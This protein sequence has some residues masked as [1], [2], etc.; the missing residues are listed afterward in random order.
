L[1]K[2]LLVAGILG[3]GFSVFTPATS[4][5]QR[6]LPTYDDFRRIDRMRR[7]NGELQT[8]E[9]M[10]VTQIDRRL[11]QQTALRATNDFQVV[12][13]GAELMGSWPMKRDLFDAALA[14]SGSNVMVALRYACTAAQQRDEDTAVALLHFAEK[15]DEGNAVPWLVELRLLQWE[16]KDFAELKLPVG[17]TIHYRDY[18][19]E[20]ARARIKLLEAAGYS[21]Y[22]AR[23]LGFAPETPVLSAARELTNQPIEKAAGPFVLSVARA[24]Q[25][26]PMYLLTELVGE[27][28]ERAATS[29]GV[30]GQTSAEANMRA[31]ELDRRRDTIKALVSSVERNAVDI[32]TE[33]EMVQ[34]FDDV[35]NLGE[36][37][38]MR[39]LAGKIQG[40]PLP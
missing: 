21:P 10:K 4:A 28:L 36:D 20:A 18:A 30:E 3:A 29:T 8:S 35:L 26:K 40:N 34:Y 7:L 2:F 6:L 13:G 23:R 19:V 22:A 16:S 31:I 39:R 11:I 37:V 32:A 27:T 1:K 12:W 17:W 9:L 38:A 15:K 5:Q 24:M 33:G 25:D 14:M